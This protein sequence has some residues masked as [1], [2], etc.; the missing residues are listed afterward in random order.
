MSDQNETHLT[1]LHK[2]SWRLK[3]VFDAVGSVPIPKDEPELSDDTTKKYDVIPFRSSPTK[4]QEAV[5][6][7]KNA[8]NESAI[9][10]S[11]HSTLEKA[12]C[13]P[14]Q[15][16]HIVGTLLN[17]KG[18]S[19]SN[20]FPISEI[21][22]PLREIQ[23]SD[24]RRAPS[25]CLIDNLENNTEIQPLGNTLPLDQTEWKAGN[26]EGIGHSQNV[27]KIKDPVKTE[28]GMEMLMLA[29]NMDEADIGR[30]AES[31][32]SVSENESDRELLTVVPAKFTSVWYSPAHVLP[33]VND[34]GGG[35]VM[36]YSTVTQSVTRSQQAGEGHPNG[37]HSGVETLVTPETETGDFHYSWGCGDVSA[38]GHVEEIED[39]ST[40][41]IEPTHAQ[42]YSH[43]QTDTEFPGP[44]AGDVAARSQC[45]SD[46]KTSAETV[47]PANSQTPERSHDKE[48]L[49]ISS[50]SFFKT[51][52][53]SVD[54]TDQEV[55]SVS[56]ETSLRNSKNV[57][58]K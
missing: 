9:L 41:E 12:D 18:H 24:E 48:D 6:V 42:Y 14:S 26:V 55:K 3:D 32:T 31:V 33:P 15:S 29:R 56:S 28:L 30:S 8:G 53:D 43:I 27:A 20:V 51:L 23:S 22:P 54:M 37:I 5:D 49:N 1:G 34:D 50:L 35:V 38:I 2:L 47:L 17:A 52:D 44:W 40:Y 36:E 4:C 39:S 7:M 21:L 46:T 13:E 57:P 19:G 25:V 11:D 10:V 58:S 16:G 45:P